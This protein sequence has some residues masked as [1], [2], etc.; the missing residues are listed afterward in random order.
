VPESKLDKA[1][2]EV[3]K[4]FGKNTVTTLT[5]SAEP[6][7]HIST[8]CSA[9]DQ[10]TGIGG[11]PRGRIT[12][13]FGPESG[14]KTTLTLQVIAQAQA[15]GGRA[16]FID[17]E[18][19]LDIKYAADLGVN[20]Q[21]L[22]VSQPDCGE[23]ALSIADLMI[24]SGA[25][26]IVV[27][28]SVAALVPRGELEGDMGD[29]QMGAQGRLMSQAM[30]KLNSKVAKTD[31]ALIFINQI[32]EKIGVMFGNNET[33]SGG[34][35]LKFFSSLRIDV[36]RIGSIKKGDAIIGNKTKVKIVKN[37]MAPPF[38]QAEPDLLFGRGFINE[39][40]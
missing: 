22:L 25:V 17:A 15:A 2:A 32:R 8:G 27:V 38:L 34:R 26:D 12:E 7:P 30:R 6:W 31:T 24:E 9:I 4:R 19:A 1:I 13:V 23:D 14:G 21:N 29:A 5:A 37:K 39:D 35:A 16:L 28:D 33:T 10:V 36:R 3:T 18:N 11:I 20:I 40:L